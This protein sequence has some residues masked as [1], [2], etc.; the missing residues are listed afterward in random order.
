M[1]QIKMSE[2]RPTKQRKSHG[3]ATATQSLEVNSTALMAAFIEMMKAQDERRQDEEARRL[4][5]EEQKRREAELRRVELEAQRREDE[6]RRQT[7][8]E[9]RRA[10]EE[11]RRREFEQEMQ[12]RHDKMMELLVTRTELSREPH[13]PR[14]K[15]HKFVE[16]SDDIGREVAKKIVGP[17]NWSQCC[18]EKGCWLT[19]S[20]MLS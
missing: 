19:L 16:G 10:R 17:D 8:E 14:A 20:W 9:D 3:G 2:D 5:R 11:Q 4:E 18:Q 12:Q 13:M 1:N 15:L 6:I 7:Q